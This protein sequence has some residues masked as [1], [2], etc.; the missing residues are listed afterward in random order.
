MSL[1]V[2]I[3]M[4]QKKRKGSSRQSGGY[5]DIDAGKYLENSPLDKGTFWF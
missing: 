4:G 5:Y 3:R 1:N 2:Q